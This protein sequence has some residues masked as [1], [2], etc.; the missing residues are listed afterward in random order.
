MVSI[1]ACACPNGGPLCGEAHLPMVHSRSTIGSV[2]CTLPFLF[3]TSRR[4]HTD[5]SHCSASMSDMS[6]VVSWE[7]HTGGLPVW[8][9]CSTRSRE[10]LVGDNLP[11]LCRIDVSIVRVVWQ[12]P[13]GEDGWWRWS[14]VWSRRCGC[15]RVCVCVCVCGCASLSAFPSTC[16][17]PT[18]APSL[19][20]VAG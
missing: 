6:M 5:G 1:C 9:S 15:V 20:C 16:F 7:S 14:S 11:R 10:G 17:C 2:P 4:P 13:T 12:R 19:A 8:S 18:R 3:I